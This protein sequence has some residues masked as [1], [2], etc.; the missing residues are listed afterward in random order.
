MIAHTSDNKFLACAL[1]AKADYIVSGDPHLTELE[2]FKG[3]PIVIP[4]AFFELL[5]RI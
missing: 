1:E 5:E 3:I 4:R 2:T